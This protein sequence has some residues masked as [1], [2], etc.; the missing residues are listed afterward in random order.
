MPTRLPKLVN[1]CAASRQ[2][3]GGSQYVW[4]EVAQRVA[5]TLTALLVLAGCVSQQKYDWLQSRCDQLN[6]T[7]SSEIGAKQMHI[8]R[9]QNA[10]KVTVN[11]QLL[12]P[13]GDWQMPVTA[14]QTIAKMIPILV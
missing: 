9:L 2:C 11:D 6:Q 14:Q 3:E 5:M 7:I 13:S 8:E 10:I 4:I 12:F 1:T